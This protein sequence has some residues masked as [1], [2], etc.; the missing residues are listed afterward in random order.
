MK[1]LIILFL[2][3]VVLIS[4]CISNQSGGEDCTQN[5]ECKSGVCDLYKQEL[6]TCAPT[7]CRPGDKTNH[8]DFYCDESGKWQ[9][10]KSIGMPCKNDLE[11]YQPSCYEVPNCNVREKAS[12]QNGLCTSETVQDECE[13]QGLKKILRSDQYNEQ[14]FESVKQMAL[15]TVC[16]PCGNSVCD[17]DLETKCNCPEDCGEQIDAGL[18]DSSLVGQEFDCGEQQEISSVSF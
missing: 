18:E 1:W 10:S 2:G 15:P 9:L 5:S 12:C 14:C 4:G 11:C 7:P 3:I 16:A 8:N 6:G 17:Q 13:K